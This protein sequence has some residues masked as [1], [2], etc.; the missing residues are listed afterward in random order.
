MT[1]HLDFA[2]AKWSDTLRLANKIVVTGRS[3]K[4]TRLVGKG[5]RDSIVTLLETN[6][7]DPQLLAIQSGNITQVSNFGFARKT[8]G[9]A[10]HSVVIRAK[11]STISGCHFWMADNSS[12]GPGALLEI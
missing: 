12:T 11:G 1:V 4:V 2:S 8:I 9:N 5:T 10:N 7:V 6:A 3:G